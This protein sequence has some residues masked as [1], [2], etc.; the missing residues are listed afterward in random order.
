[1]LMDLFNDYAHEFIELEE[2]VETLTLEAEQIDLAL[3]FSQQAHPDQKWSVYLQKLAQFGFEKWLQKREPRLQIHPPI[4]SPGLETI[5]QLQVGEFKVCIIPVNGF[6]EVEIMIPR[7]I[8]ELPE[9]AAH[10]YVPIGVAEDVD[11]TAVLG[12]I[13]YNQL[14]NYQ[15]QLQPLIDWTYAIPREWFNPDT[16]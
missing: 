11:L 12:F 4:S 10:F 6:S 5:C 9:F 3:Q 8:V 7:A 15:S 1:M 14:V 16:G 13:P 2:T